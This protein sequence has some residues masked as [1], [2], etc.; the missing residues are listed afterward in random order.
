MTLQHHPVFEQSAGDGMAGTGEEEAG[1]MQAHLREA[2]REYLS[3]KPGEEGRGA[4]D[5]DADMKGQ[6]DGQVGALPPSLFSSLTPCCCCCCCCCCFLQSLRYDLVVPRGAGSSQGDG[7]GDG[8]TPW[9]ASKRMMQLE[10]RLQSIERVLGEDPASYGRLSGVQKL[11]EGQEEEKS[12]SSSGAGGENTV[13]DWRLR[14]RLMAP[15]Y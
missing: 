8:G 10:S 6:S 9:Y 2:I 15:S 11:F 4:G 7:T 3:A 1:G 12:S 13:K 5:A 14:V